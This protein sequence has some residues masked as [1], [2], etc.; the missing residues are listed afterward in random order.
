LSRPVENGEARVARRDVGR[1]RYSISE[2]NSLALPQ[3]LADVELIGTVTHLIDL[4]GDMRIW[5]AG[6]SVFLDRRLSRQQG[7]G[8]KKRRVR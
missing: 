8:R 4:G 3:T 1:L 6:P 2:L 7:V 5:L